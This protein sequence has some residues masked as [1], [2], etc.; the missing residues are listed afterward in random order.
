MLISTLEPEEVMELLGQPPEKADDAQEVLLAYTQLYDERGG[1][2]EIE[3]KESKQ[4]LGITR[5][6]KKSYAG[7]QMVMLL[8]T[9]AHNVVVWA[10]KWLSS[11]V[12][13]LKSYGVQRMVR[14]LR[15]VSGFLEIGKADAIKRVVLN[16]ASSLARVT[17]KALG[18]LLKAEHV[19]VI[20]GET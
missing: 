18:A 7:Q 12:P 6:R 2:I 9:L 13:K 16:G 11:T 15:A 20:L 10:K 5:R 19:S 4:G 17:A 14:D 8:G 3:I 1:A